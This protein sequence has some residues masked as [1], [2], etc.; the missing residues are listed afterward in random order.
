MTKTCP[1]GAIVPTGAP[2]LIPGRP[3]GG[4]L[5]GLDFKTVGT[6]R[7]IGTEQV[8]RSHASVPELVDDRRDATRVGPATPPST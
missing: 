1:G 8:T 7:P 3:A 5:L 6:M 2:C 4:E